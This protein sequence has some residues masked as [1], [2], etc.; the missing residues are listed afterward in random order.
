MHAYDIVFF[1]T[2]QKQINYVSNTNKK[3][4]SN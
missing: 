1:V 2:I 4:V 3:Q